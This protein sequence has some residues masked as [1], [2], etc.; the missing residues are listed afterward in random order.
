ML[1]SRQWRLL[2]LKLPRF[3]AVIATASSAIRD[4]IKHGF[5][6]VQLIT[7]VIKAINNSDSSGPVIL[8]AWKRVCYTPRLFQGWVEYDNQVWL[9]SRE[10]ETFLINKFNHVCIR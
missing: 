3:I 8:E 1:K 5:P 7:C 10:F 9:S 2:V 6:D 4:A